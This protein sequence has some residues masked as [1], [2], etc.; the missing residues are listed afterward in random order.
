MIGQVVKID[1][2]VNKCKTKSDKDVFL[3]DLLLYF[4]LHFQHLVLV[5]LIYMD[6]IGFIDIKM[7]YNIHCD[8]GVHQ[9][10][11]IVYIEM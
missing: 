1:I 4:I 7:M 2:L 8:N 5:S 3:Q 11:I 6:E 10:F 9:I